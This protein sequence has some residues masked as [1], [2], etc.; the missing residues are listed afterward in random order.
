[1]AGGVRVLVLVLL[2]GLWEVLV[3]AVGF[4]VE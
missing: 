1:M 4:A 2:A 3:V